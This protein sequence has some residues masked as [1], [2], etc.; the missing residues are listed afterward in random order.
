[1]PVQRLELRS[2]SL[3]GWYIYALH[4]HHT[5]PLEALTRIRTGGCWFKAK[6][7]HRPHHKNCSTVAE[8]VTLGGLEPPRGAGSSQHVEKQNKENEHERKKKKTTHA[9][10]VITEKKKKNT[11]PPPP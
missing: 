10:P 1:M 3:E 5:G 8:A 4:L 9:P 6:R 2:R 7:V 11:T